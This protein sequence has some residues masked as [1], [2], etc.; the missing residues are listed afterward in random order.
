MRG[1]NPFFFSCFIPRVGSSPHA[2]GKPSSRLIGFP[3]CGLIPA[4]AGKT[5]RVACFSPFLGAHPRMRGENGKQGDFWTGA[6]GSSPHARGKHAV[7]HP[8]APGIGLIPACAG[9]TNAG[10]PQAMPAKAHPRMRGENPIWLCPQQ[11]GIGSSPH[12]RGKHL[13][14]WINTVK[15]SH[16]DSTYHAPLLI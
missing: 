13:A 10:N 5:G 9:K 11:S 3:P 15:W 1:E 7:F 4:C 12:A 2:R 8:F 14:T 16:P 6:A